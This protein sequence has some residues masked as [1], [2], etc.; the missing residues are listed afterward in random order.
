MPVNYDLSDNIRK[1]MAQDEPAVKSA[2]CKIANAS[3]ETANEEPCGI[4]KYEG[5]IR[6]N[7]REIVIKANFIAED[8]QRKRVIIPEETAVL[9]AIQEVAYLLEKHGIKA[10][11]ERYGECHIGDP[12]RCLTGIA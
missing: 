5:G 7:R 10:V 1:M 8:W 2:L 4:G 3:F 11:R 12:L 6:V 9:H